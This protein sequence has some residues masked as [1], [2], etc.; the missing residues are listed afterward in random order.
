MSTHTDTDTDTDASSPDAQMPDRYKP[1]PIL[2][3]AVSHASTDRDG[4]PSAKLPMI[5][6]RDWLG[7]TPPTTLSIAPRDDAAVRI[8]AGVPSICDDLTVGEARKYSGPY[9]TATLPLSVLEYLGADPGDEL[10]VEH[11]GDNTLEVRLRTDT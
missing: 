11:V 10:A 7:V 1:D 4:T 6:L 5:A 9:P 3:S 8:G 2:T